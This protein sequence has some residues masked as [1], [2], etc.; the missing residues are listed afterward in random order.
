MRSLRAREFTAIAIAVVVS[1]ETGAI[2][3]AMGGDLER[4]LSAD[5]LRTRLHTLL[6]HRRRRM[7]R[8]EEA[9]SSL[10]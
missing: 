7:R 3:L 4:H 10:A 9:R 5:S 6:G 8:S 1:E 2:S